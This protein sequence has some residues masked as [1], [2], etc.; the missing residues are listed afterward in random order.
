MVGRAVAS[1]AEVALA[2]A[3]REPG[4]REGGARPSEPWSCGGSCCRRECA[5]TARPRPG[6]A[7]GLQASPR[8]VGG[9]GMAAPWFQLLPAQRLRAARGSRWARAAAAGARALFR[10]WPRGGAGSG[11]Q[12]C[13]PREECGFLALPAGDSAGARPSACT[14]RCVG[15]VLFRCLCSAR[16]CAF[17]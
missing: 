5:G 17:G 12:R 7:A 3:P 11:P 15:L 9:G 14:A 8:Y 1:E 10:R 2:Q 16:C 13:H 4:P 6:Q